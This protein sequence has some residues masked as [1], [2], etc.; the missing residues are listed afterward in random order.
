MAGDTA[1][2]HRSSPTETVL[3][4]GASSGI[5]QEMA[6]LFARNGAH[7]VLVARREERLADLARRL[8]DRWSASSTILP[9]DLARPEAPGDLSR[10]VSDRGLHVDVL[11]NNAGFGLHG[12]VAE[13]DLQSQ[14]DMVAVNVAALTELT[15]LFLPDMLERGRGG[16]LN[17]ASTAAFQPGPSMTIYYA[18]KAYVLSFSEGL[19]EELAGTGV[20][21]TCLAPGPTETEFQAEAGMERSLLLKTGT[22][23]AGRVAEI[24]YRGFRRGRTLVIPGVLNRL[25]ALSVRFAPR[26][27]VRKTVKLL[28]RQ[29]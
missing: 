19:A 25:G 10:S 26:S 13:L 15:R 4:T 2:P 28:H 24:G 14:M 1:T 7:L 8:E 11:V 6:T 12:R 27:L 22:M 9:F 18:T 29:D 3:L 20:D 21:V 23:D 17:V 5:G 16:I